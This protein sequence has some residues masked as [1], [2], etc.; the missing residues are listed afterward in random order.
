M[1]FITAFMIKN[2]LYIILIML[3]LFLL[4]NNCY[5]H[6][7]N[8]YYIILRIYIFIFIYYCYGFW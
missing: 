1:A 8:K 3:N 4:K 2:L 5:K 6:T 7:N